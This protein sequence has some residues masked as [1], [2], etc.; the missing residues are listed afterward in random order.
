VII[1]NT[2]EWKTYITEYLGHD[3]LFTTLVWLHTKAHTALIIAE[4][5]EQPEGQDE[6]RADEGEEGEP[7][8]GVEGTT[9][10]L[11]EEEI[12]TVAEGRA[13][14]GQKIPALI[15]QV[16]RWWRSGSSGNERGW[17]WWR[18]CSTGRMES[19]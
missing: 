15:E 5:E 1:S 17:F 7:E 16:E 13:D 3:V 8:G 14:E 10:E 18:E 12:E 2:N 9:N 11:E 19:D 6:G 4:E